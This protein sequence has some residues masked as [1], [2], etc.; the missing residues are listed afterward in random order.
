MNILFMPVFMGWVRASSAQAS[1]WKPQKQSHQWNVT[2]TLAGTDVERL[3]AFGVWVPQTR[4]KV[5]ITLLF[6]SSVPLQTAQTV[7]L[8]VAA[9]TICW[10][11]HHI[12]VMWVEFGKFPLNDASF[13][14]RIVSH[15]L[16]YGN[17]CVNPILYAFLSENFRRARHQVFTCHF[18]FPPPFNNKVTRCRMENCSTTHSI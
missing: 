5:L 13:V 2:S 15:C 4:R 8:L 3:L 14:F 11:P 16:S 10:M 18:L 17:S 6:V 7:L 12:I 9:F 1:G